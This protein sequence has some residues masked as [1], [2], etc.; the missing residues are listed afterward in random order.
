MSARIAAHLRA[1]GFGL[2]AVRRRLSSHLTYADVM[3]TLLAF[4]VL[5]GGAAYAANTVFSGDITDNQVYSADVRND[6]LA[7][8]GLAAADLRSD[9]V[10]TAELIRNSIRSGDVRD[11]SLPDGGLTAT[12]LRQGSVGSPEVVN[13]ALRKEDL[14]PTVLAGLARGN[15]EIVVGQVFPGESDGNGS[16]TI[17]SI[18]GFA[19][20][21]VETCDLGAAA[22]SQRAEF[23]VYNTSPDIENVHAQSARLGML[24]PTSM[25][26]EGGLV[27]Y[28]GAGAAAEDMWTFSIGT[29]SSD[30]SGKVAQVFV[31]TFATSNGCG[32]SAVGIVGTSPA[33]GPS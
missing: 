17:L 25:L 24:Q 1:N 10:D 21:T 4:L 14:D 6:N 31:N 29:G 27:G 13:G 20:F 15:A 23:G 5:G 3:V 12:D 33:P 9:S 11:D 19:D 18:P 8:G 32:F 16:P 28:G 26:S 7:G 30:N 22:E 2:I